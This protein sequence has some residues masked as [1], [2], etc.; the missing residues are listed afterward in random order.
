MSACRKG[1]YK[2]FFASGHCSMFKSEITF[3]L[4]GGGKLNRPEGTKWP[5]SGTLSAGA[6]EHYIE[7]SKNE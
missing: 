1:S 2:T 6:H 5:G 7:S 4:D 3:C